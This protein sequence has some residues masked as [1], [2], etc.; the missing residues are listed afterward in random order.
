MPTALAN[1]LEITDSS[2]HHIHE[3]GKPFTLHIKNN[4]LNLID[5][6]WVN[7]QG[8]PLTT[9]TT[10]FPN[11]EIG[12]KSPSDKV[13]Y[14]GLRIRD[15]KG[16]RE[17]GFAILP[18]RSLDHKKSRSV[19]SSSPF[20][21]VHTD[22]QDPYMDNWTKTATWETYDVG[23][24]K[25]AMEERREL[26][27]TELPIITGGSWASDD[28][29]A[30]SMFQ[31]EELK[32]ELSSYFK[33]DPHTNFWELGLEENLTDAYQQPFY[34]KNLLTKVKVA[35]V[36]ANEN[37]RNIQFIYQIAGNGLDDVEKFLKHPSAEFFHVLSLHPYAWPDFPDPD[38]WLID[39][40]NDVKKLVQKHQPDLR[41]WFTEIGAPQH[42]HPEGGIFNFGEAKNVRGHSRREA[43]RFMMRLTTLAL[44]NGIEKIFWYNYRDRGNLLA[45]PEN[46]F[47]LRDF[48]GFPK[49]AYLT[50][51]LLSDRLHNARPEKSLT[52]SNRVQ[53]YRFKKRTE[54]CTVAWTADNKEYDVEIASLLGKNTEHFEALDMTG[55]ELPQRGSSVKVGIDPILV[56]SLRNN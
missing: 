20:G 14:Y 5:L 38:E 47:G 52:L 7:F 44:H 6:H 8:K 40:L 49:P 10:V 34:W 55:G 11:E 1:G 12:L 15:P 24:W 53:T 31:L 3:P 29:A 32:A 36:A 42:I 28:I 50:Y 54:T 18:P 41:L 37:N 13:G 45:D 33:A 25:Q 30:I 56:C 23:Y 16:L 39:Y 43:S 48:N 22:N 9:T 21:M 19:K 27:T 51:H 2:Q 35:Q 4:G 17:T 46:F 26:G